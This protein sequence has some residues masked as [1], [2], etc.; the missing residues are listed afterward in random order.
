MSKMK[1]SQTILKPELRLSDAPIPVER[2]QT[3]GIRK[4][5]LERQASVDAR[6]R[7][8]MREIDA[9]GERVDFASVARRAGVSRQSIYNRKAV[10]QEIETLRNAF[11]AAPGTKRPVSE[12]A[13]E[14]STKARLYLLHDENKR[15]KADNVQL[16]Q[17]IGELLSE[18]RDARNRSKSSAT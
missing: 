9:D 14:A 2:K 12:R 13:T 5:A 11:D 18:Q 15:L 17:R 7:Q 4:A 3:A 6:I 8:A 16:R 10:A 1:T